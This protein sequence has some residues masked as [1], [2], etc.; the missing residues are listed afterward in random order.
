MRFLTVRERYPRDDTCDAS[1]RFPLSS[2]LSSSLRP[3]PPITFRDRRISTDGGREGNRKRDRSIGERCSRRK[4]QDFISRL[5][6]LFLSLFYFTRRYH[7]RRR[8]IRRY[9]IITISRYREMQLFTFFVVIIAHS[10]DGESKINSLD[11]LFR[12]LTS[13][14]RCQLRATFSSAKLNIYRCSICKSKYIS[15]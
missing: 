12:I 11:V 5:H 1:L 3:L 6:F 8:C 7:R 2:C 9:I 4:I 13:L 14:S 15:R 10:F